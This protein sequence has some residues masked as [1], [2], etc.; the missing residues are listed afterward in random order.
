MVVNYGLIALEYIVTEMIRKR[1]RYISAMNM[2]V[3]LTTNANITT[4][5]LRH[6]WSSVAALRFRYRI[7]AG[8]VEAR[9]RE[10]ADCYGELRNPDIHT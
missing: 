2:S 9:G 6:V 8:P 7:G 10:N 1:A 4:T 3:V 5:L